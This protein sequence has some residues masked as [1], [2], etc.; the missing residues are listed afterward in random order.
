MQTIEQ[1]KS[2]GIS[3]QQIIVKELA[4]NNNDPVINKLINIAEKGNIDEVE[5]IVR[6]LYKD[7]G[8]NFDKE[9]SEFMKQIR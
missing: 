7:K 3:P 8:T 4:L 6:N 9:F 5:K 1:A 2:K